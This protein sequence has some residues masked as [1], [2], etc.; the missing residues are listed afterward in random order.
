MMRHWFV[1]ENNIILRTELIELHDYNGNHAHTE[2]ELSVSNYFI[3]KYKHSL[4]KT[5]II[6]ANIESQSDVTRFIFGM[7]LG[8]FI[9]R[10][11]SH[12]IF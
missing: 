10:R 2:G 9:I 5:L 3:M 4:Y 12:V 8:N 6:N 7:I 11:Y 1:W